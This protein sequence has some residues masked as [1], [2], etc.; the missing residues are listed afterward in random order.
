MKIP[1]PQLESTK[2]RFHKSASI[3]NRHGQGYFLSSSPLDFAR[4]KV[5]NRPSGSKTGKTNEKHE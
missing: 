1:P 2:R 3:S 5:S 4:L